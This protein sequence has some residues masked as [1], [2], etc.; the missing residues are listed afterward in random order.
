MLVN[1]IAAK[2]TVILFDAS[3][4]GK[5]SGQVP[6]TFEGWA[7]DIGAFVKALGFEQVDLLGFSL[8][9]RAGKCL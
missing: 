8:G 7:D 3:G 9:G 2:R 5:T 6:D 1:R 4:I